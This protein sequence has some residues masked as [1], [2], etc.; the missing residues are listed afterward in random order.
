[1]LHVITYFLITDHVVAIAA[2]IYSKHNTTM[3]VAINILF[4]WPLQNQ[5]ILI[6]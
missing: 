3:M 4:Q 2:E 6:S 1:M 5:A